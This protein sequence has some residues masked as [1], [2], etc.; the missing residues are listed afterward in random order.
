MELGLKMR[1]LSGHVTSRE[2][3]VLDFPE[4][5][6]VVLSFPEMGEEV[7][8]M[9]VSEARRSRG[10]KREAS[11]KAAHRVMAISMLKILSEEF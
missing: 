9:L 8:S 5:E 3:F 1:L 11:E 2:G 7:S 4:L 6:K 10:K